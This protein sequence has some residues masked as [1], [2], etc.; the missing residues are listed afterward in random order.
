M[1]CLPQ[2]LHQAAKCGAKE[3]I[4][5]LDEVT[6][7]RDASADVD[8]L[9]SGPVN[10]RPFHSGELRSA[11]ATSCTEAHPVLRSPKQLRLHPALDELNFIEVVGELNRAARLES[12]NAAE[13]ILITTNGIILAGFG[14][15]RLAI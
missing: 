8:R 3:K 11:L 4:M 13:P 5:Q 9:D 15:W 7:A 14:R 10:C 1:R 12:Q 6:S 2:K